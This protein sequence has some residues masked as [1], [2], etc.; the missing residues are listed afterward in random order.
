MTAMVGMTL[1]FDLDGTLVDTAPDLIGA[2][3]HALASLGLGPADPV[4]QRGMVSFGARRMIEDALAA[5]SHTALD[6]QIEHLHQMFLTHYTA[7]IARDSRTFDD[8]GVVLE[9]FKLEGARLA[10]CTNKKESLSRQLLAEVGLAALFDA[11]A[12]IDTLA[13]AKPHGGHVLGAIRLAGGDPT[14]AVMVGDSENDIKS[15]RAAHVPVIACNFGY[16][17]PPVE[18]FNP[19]AVIGHYR[20]LPSAVSAA[21]AR[22]FASSS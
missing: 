15:A 20:D 14:R 9:R 8:V 11:I 16:S 22:V 3:N 7:N 1:V 13:I 6:G 10:V 5:A 17:D 19:D 21:H 18:T 12:G 4:R 2:T